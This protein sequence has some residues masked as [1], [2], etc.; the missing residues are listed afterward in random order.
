MFAYFHSVGT[1]PSSSD[2]LKKIASGV[3]IW[4][5]NFLKQFWWYPINPT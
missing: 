4:L 5:N 2:K 3:L 1:I